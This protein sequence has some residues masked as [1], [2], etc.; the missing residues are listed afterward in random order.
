[1][2]SPDFPMILRILGA[3][4]TYEY[5]SLYPWWIQR[6]RLHSL[7]KLGQSFYL[8]SA[9]QQVV[10]FSRVVPIFFQYIIDLKMGS[11]DRHQ[12]L[13]LP[14]S[15][16]ISGEVEIWTLGWRFVPGARWFFLGSAGPAILEDFFCGIDRDFIVKTLV[17]GLMNFFI[18]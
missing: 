18:F 6:D 17:D 3:H 8:P 16:S 15:W 4:P 11:D 1:M 12:I 5:S 14:R 10:Y 2:V 13:S 7:W 9:S